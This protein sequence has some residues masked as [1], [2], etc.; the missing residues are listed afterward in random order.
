M[1]DLNELPSD[2]AT[3]FLVRPVHPIV[4][5]YVRGLRPPEQLLVLEM[6]A[7]ARQRGISLAGRL[8]GD[9]LYA[10]ALATGA[11]RIFEIGS[12]LGYVTGWLARAVAD[13]GRVYCADGD[14]DNRR[15]ARGF[16]ER[17]GLWERV[18]Y[19]VG[20]PAEVLDRTTGDFDL[21]YN[22]GDQG[23][24]PLVWRMARERLL[25]GG[26]Y[27]AHHVF[28]GG[29]VF[30]QEVEDDVRP[31]WTEAVKEH[32]DLVAADGDFDFFVNPVGDGLMV[33]R[34]KGKRS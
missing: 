9:F 3:P 31:G 10:M 1:D 8:V 15:R 16:L 28:W 26:L 23:D 34:K 5:A 20:V 6:E 19:E 4:E 33:A 18:V 13:E 25:P 11:R 29:R 21:I 7:V 32:N 24:Y 27:I 17:A 30:F 22:D 12:G 2:L 14:P